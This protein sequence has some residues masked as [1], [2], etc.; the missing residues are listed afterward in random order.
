M[1]RIS[2]KLAFVALILFGAWKHWS[3]RPVPLP[4][5]GTIAPGDPIQTS[6]SGK[7]YEKGNYQLQ[8]L[9]NFD[10]EAR[11]L[12]KETYHLDRES[13]L[14]PVDLAL[15]WGAMSNSTVLEKL[16]ITQ[17]NRFYFYR[18]E[19]DPPIPPSEIASH[20]ANMHLIPVNSEVESQ[21]KQARVGQ[22]VHI[23]GELVEARA[24][25]G[26]HWRSSLTRFDSGAGACELV[27]VESIEL[28]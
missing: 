18:W 25:D 10:I 8:A 19:N 14:A 20:S 9:A 24:P 3:E 5:A 7:I 11:V 4:A 21:M 12:S 28:R 2:W 27:R 6:T 26:W 16:K 1:F 13:D 23:V 22:V 17:S 15:G